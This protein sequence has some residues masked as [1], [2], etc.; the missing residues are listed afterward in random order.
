MRDA[1]SRTGFF[2]V[3][4]FAGVP[5]HVVDAAFDAAARFFT[6]DTTTKIA[7]CAWEAETN[8]GY[9]AIGRER[10][11]VSH[12]DVGKE[13]LNLPRDSAATVLAAVA[14]TTDKADADALAA[15]LD[16]ASAAALALLAAIG[17][18]MG[19]DDIAA[20]VAA[21]DASAAPAATS[22][23]TLRALHYSPITDSDGVVAVD[24]DG[25]VLRAGAH[26]DYGTI[27]LLFR[28]DRGV[29]DNDPAS[30]SDDLEVLVGNDWIRV[31]VVRNT[32]V[33]NVGDLL[34]DWSTGLFP[35]TLHRVRGRATAHRFA[36]ALF[37]H[38]HDH[39]AVRNMPGLTA[40]DHL[41]SRLEASY[42]GTPSQS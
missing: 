12:P 28:D 20:F 18:A 38:P 14:A 32:V 23:T 21:H 25:C 1:A 4:D 11:G 2:L 34:H 22:G 10:L 42:T 8:A 35:S 19:D 9:V 31:P 39:I 7:A 27:T 3:D 13:A 36:L 16:A 15:L 40:G 29:D 33:V 24:D 6:A 26:T 5:R 17:E 41:R 30:T 37:V